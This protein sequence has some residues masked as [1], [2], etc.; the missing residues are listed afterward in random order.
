M[1]TVTIDVEQADTQQDAETAD[2]P[3][4]NHDGY[5]RPPFEL[6]VVVKR[7]HQ[8]YSPPGTR[9]PF[10]E[11]EEDPLHNNR[12]GDDHEYST[13]QYKQYLGA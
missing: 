11:L 12:T 4:S 8:K 13:D 6:K 3:E 9:G 2:D 5:L 10:G 1:L 7:A